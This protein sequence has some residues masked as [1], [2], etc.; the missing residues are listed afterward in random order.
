[1]ISLKHLA[2]ESF[3]KLS[4][5]VNDEVPSPLRDTAGYANTARLREICQP[6]DY[7][8]WQI[9]FEHGWY[10]PAL[11]QLCQ[12]NTVID[13]INPAL[14]AHG[15]DAISTALFD[16]L[17]SS[18]PG[19][20]FSG[21]YYVM[22]AS[23]FNVFLSVVNGRTADI[24]AVR[25]FSMSDI[26]VD[27][28]LAY[29]WNTGA[30]TSLIAKSP[31]VPTTYTV[32][33]TTPE[34]CSV[35]ASTQVLVNNN[36]SFEIYDTIRRGETYVK[37]GFDKT[38][39]GIYK[40]T[41][42]NGK[43]CASEIILHLHVLEPLPPTVFEASICEGE[44][45]SLHN[46]TAWETGTYTQSWT[47]VDGRDSTVILN[48]T[49]YPVDT[50]KIEKDICPGGRY[51][52]YGFDATEAGTYVGSIPAQQGCDTIVILQLNVL[53]EH[54]FSE[55]KTICQGETYDFGGETLSVAGVYYDS[56]KTVAG[57]DSIY[58]LILNVT[59]NI[60]KTIEASIC[61]GERYTANGFDENE[62]GT[63]TRTSPAQQGCDTVVTLTLN[64]LPDYL[65]D[66]EK[67][68]CQGE[69][70]DFGGKTLSS[71][72][73]YYDSCKTIAGCDSIYRLILN[74]TDNITKTIEASICPGGRYT[75]NDFDE[76]EPGTYTRT[77]PAR[78]GCDTVVTLT[79]DFLPDYLF[80]DER[81]IE[82]G[83]S[84]DFRGQWLSE[85]GI[86][87]D[88]LKTVAGCDSVYLLKL[89]VSVPIEEDEKTIIPNTF[90]P[91]GDGI[92]DVFMPGHRVRIVN[93]NGVVIFNGE[94]GWDGSF[95]GGQASEG[96]YF[97]ILF[98]KADDK[99]K[100]KN[101]TIT[102]YITLVR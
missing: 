7:G 50:L 71:P 60:T 4:S 1:M 52:D 98:P 84:F 44:I 25:T 70:Y 36:S 65:F 87:Y 8:I 51:T 99:N 45:Y 40:K 74:V 35:E 58:K 79:L 2:V 66:E 73:I 89:N 55:E 31:S 11:G 75:A 54:F 18:T 69:T 85:E 86:Y 5:N 19:G 30:T 9:D 77:I 33:A 94:N 37:Y 29:Q 38:E 26:L 102:G 91:N 15:G 24:R 6:G 83:E 95:K 16:D 68:I 49:V 100:N 14:K 62:A 97:Y 3:C 12:L 90:S 81:T 21:R 61:P 63:Y 41:M 48:L 92:N 42:E 28:T 13:V 64:F 76:T 34:G 43:G 93:R 47:S 78:Q 53:P 23:G 32:K 39:P 57:C 17:L 101:K 22:Y 27:T 67:T 88:S 72:G 56:C 82:R 96:V 59:D 46:F 20:K 10:I 80:D